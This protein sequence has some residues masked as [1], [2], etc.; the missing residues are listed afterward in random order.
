LTFSRQRNES[1]YLAHAT[2]A[3]TG[4]SQTN[5]LQIPIAQ[6]KPPSDS[7]FDPAVSSPEY[8]LTPAPNADLIPRLLLVGRH[9]IILNNSGINGMLEYQYV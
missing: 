8:Y 3:A 6:L 1:R 4:K 9:L 5:T 7:G 2:T